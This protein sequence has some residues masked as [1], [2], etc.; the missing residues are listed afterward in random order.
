SPRRTRDAK[1]PRAAQRFPGHTAQ[2]F[3]FFIMLFLQFTII[4]LFPLIIRNRPNRSSPNAGPQS[5]VST[6]IFIFISIDQ[7]DLAGREVQALAGFVA[8]L[9]DSYETPRRPGE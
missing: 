1:N 8:A 3:K 9:P 2:E 6:L 7:I 5:L 4:L